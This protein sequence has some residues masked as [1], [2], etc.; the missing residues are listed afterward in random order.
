[1]SRIMITVQ[2]QPTVIQM[3]IQGLGLVVRLC[4]I[5]NPGVQLIVVQVPGV[6]ALPFLMLGCQV[7]G[8]M[9]LCSCVRKPC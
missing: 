6:I 4:Q 2:I 3:H 9:Y 7:C 5:R 1:M 8:T